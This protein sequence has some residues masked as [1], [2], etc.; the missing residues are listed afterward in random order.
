[1][2][3]YK[4]NGYTYQK[5]GEKF[6]NFNTRAETEPKKAAAKPAPA[7]KAAPKIEPAKSTLAAADRAPSMK[8]TPKKPLELGGEGY[9]LGPIRLKRYPSAELPKD[10]ALGVEWEGFK[11]GGKIDGIAS[12]GKTKGRYC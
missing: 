1:M 6:Q 4:K 9:K 10:G 7:K 3:T 12:R 8:A 5:S 2:A 11:N